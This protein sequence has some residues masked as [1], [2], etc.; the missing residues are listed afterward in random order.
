MSMW[1]SGSSDEEII[2]KYGQKEFDKLKA[3]YGEKSIPPSDLYGFKP[4]LD[5]V[6]KQH[7]GIIG[8]GAKLKQIIKK[9]NSK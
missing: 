1:N 9:E 8:P 7:H 3:K 5:D 6:Q 4:K 2:K